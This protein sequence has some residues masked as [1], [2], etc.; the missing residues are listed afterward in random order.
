M[1]RKYLIYPLIIICIIISL[2]TISFATI[3]FS[4]S[5]Q[6]Y[7]LKYAIT[8]F[9]KTI[10]ADI[11]FEKL[12]GNLF[13][14]L[15]IKHLKINYQKKNLVSVNSVQLKYS[16]KGFFS[17]N[18]EISD[19][20][21]D[22]LYINLII[23]PDSSLNLISAFKSASPK[24]TKNPFSMGINLRNLSIN[25]AKIVVKSQLANY[26]KTSLIDHFQIKTSFYYKKNQFN[27]LTKR[28]AFNWDTYPIKLLD[29][30]IK[31]TEKLLSTR[32]SRLNIGNSILS[33]DFKQVLKDQQMNLVVI[34]KQINTSDLNYWVK[35]LK[36]PPNSFQMDLNASKLKNALNVKLI[37]RDQTDNLIIDANTDNYLKQKYSAKI[38]FNNFN[39]LKPF[40]QNQLRL[41][42]QMDLELKGHNIQSNSLQAKLNLKKLQYQDYLINNMLSNVRKVQD[43]VFLTINSNIYST[44]YQA[45]VTASNIFKE[46]IFTGS[47]NLLHLNIATLLEKINQQK[48]SN[49]IESDLNLNLSFQGQGT[50]FKKMLLYTNIEVD[51]SMI[52]GVAIDSALITLKKVNDKVSFNLNVINQPDNSLSAQG[53]LDHLFSLNSQKLKHTSFLLSMQNP[54]ALQP[55]TTKSLNFRKFL[56]SGNLEGSLKQLTLSSQ[57]NL[58]NAQY[59]S[60]FADSVSIYLEAI[61]DFNHEL[62]IKSPSKLDLK[63]SGLKYNNFF[64][65]TITL[66]SKLENDS[67][68]TALL[69]TQSD[70]LQVSSNFSIDTSKL[71][72]FKITQLKIAWNKEVIQNHEKSISLKLSNNKIELKNFNLSDSTSSINSNLLLD[73]QKNISFDFNLINFNLRKI[74]PF[75]SNN[76]FDSGFL[77]AKINIDK[78]LNQPDISAHV[79]FNQIITPYAKLDSLSVFL[80][81]QHD[82]LSIKSKTMLDQQSLDIYGTL[83]M[84]FNLNTLQN[85]QFYKQNKP[86]YLNVKSDSMNLKFLNLLFDNKASLNGLLSADFSIT[87]KNNNLNTTGYI[88]I[89]QAG[90]L[91]PETGTKLEN[92][93]AILHLKN[94]QVWLD[95]LTFRA[96]KGH[97][98]S[99]GLLAFSIKQGFILDSLSLKMKGSNL[100]LLNYSGINSKFDSNLTLNAN[101]QLLSLKGDISTHD[102]K[103]NITKLTNKK[104]NF[105]LT[106]PLLIGNIN[107][108]QDTNLNTQSKKPKLFNLINLDLKLHIPRNTWISGK[109]LNLE[110]SGDL[111]LERHKNI[112]LLNGDINV[113]RG[114][115]ALYGKRFN[116]ESGTISFINDKEMNPNLSIQAIYRFKEGLDRRTIQLNISGTLK[117]PK[118]SFLLD[119]I[120]IEEKDAFSYIAFGKNLD[121]LT[122]KQQSDV[123]NKFKAEAFAGSMLLNS[124]T[125]KINDRLKDYLALDLVDITG[126]NQFGNTEIQVGKYF[127]DRFFVSYSREFNITSA[128]T[129]LNESVNFEYQINK[130]FFLNSINNNSNSSGLDIIYKWSK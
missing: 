104:G 74:N 79:F 108:N 26:L 22:S 66:N 90:F 98:Y 52:S 116:L 102:A 97:F 24:K 31:K 111:D 17:N 100:H 107:Q 103:I 61:S 49:L 55:L 48:S 60:V 99:N 10:K 115:Y 65:K 6:Q 13:H 128:N 16:L 93:L 76:L 124:F 122:N 5:L 42:G 67:I 35:S 118:L 78:N 77:N 15:T 46:F 3:Y 81:Q 2:V 62:F 57:I 39:L 125:G 94:N 21:L 68:Q 120:E 8:Q 72:E 44:D 92:L 70:S 9:Q 1:K 119:G 43:Q 27:S 14:N 50:D 25:N 56:V 110:I 105:E 117:K 45:Q 19:L 63:T 34:S 53:E 71:L 84:Q 123:N 30:N 40:N 96:G 18:I 127:G 51:S 38:S 47:I 112:L 11:S 83:P 80:N 113:L 87:N 32:L 29:L 73:L 126:S 86:F 88:K 20:N 59:D 130:Y 37:I 33:L 23:S 4:T 28:L 114:Y 89:D 58:T 121:Q 101:S 69:I 7:L 41:I 64:F 95:S 82:S 91:Y 54:S 129:A 12:E 75:L 85:K 109:D 106:P 36:L